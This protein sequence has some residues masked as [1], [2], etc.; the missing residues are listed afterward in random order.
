MGKNYLYINGHVMTGEVGQRPV[1]AVAVNEGRIVAVGDEVEVRAWS[2]PSTE[3]IDLKGRTMAPG[4]YDAHC[5]PMGVGF[6]LQEVNAATPPNRT[7]S[8][9]VNRFSE[10]VRTTA[11][12]EWI[13]ASGYDDA[14]LAENR[15][16]TRHDLDPISPDNPVVVM[17]ACHHIAAVNSKALALAGITRNTPDPEGGTIDRDEHG[18]PTGVIR[19]AA[20]SKGR[21]AIA[22]PTTE[23]IQDALR[24]AGQQYLSMGVTSVA[25]AGIRRA[26]EFHAYQG[27]SERGE[28]PVRTYLM[29]MIDETL[30]PLA[31]L[32]IRTGFGD[33]RLRIGPA[34]IF[35]DG[36][37][38]GRT[39][40]MSQPY[41][42]QDDN[43]GLWMQDPQL[44]KNKLKAAH[45]AGFQCCAH[46]IGDAAIELLIESFEEALREDPRPNSRHRIEH[47]SIL[48]PD[49]IDRIQKIGAIPVPG[50]SFLYAFKNAYIQNLG[51]DR[52]RYAYAMRTFF[53]RGIVAP[54][55]TDAP[56]VSTSAMIG[57]QTMVTRRS[58]EGDV[59]WPEE[60][61]SLEQAVRAYTWNGAYASFEEGIKGTIE[62]GKLAD[63]VVLETDLS[64]VKPEELGTVQ[65][66]MTIREGEIVY[67]R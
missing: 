65:V 59:I 52:I 16:P 21:A 62:P 18:E 5:H 24:L 10:R 57:I 46:A 6:A 40:R 64:D 56:V 58:E 66:D 36:S 30:E 42:D 32:G 15:H 63:L 39:A 48:R 33:A 2:S 43:L 34:K 54:A 60:R 50:T 29:M 35:L 67:Q 44:M 8:D 51:M 3:V 17:R 11:A 38:G 55:S 61:I 53:E 27:L 49:L 9:I 19:E 1:S 4:F 20:L 25:E 22:E 45:K 28:L 47:S 37:I 14:R 7:V 31:Q 23:M 41:E 13:I 12:G 26:E